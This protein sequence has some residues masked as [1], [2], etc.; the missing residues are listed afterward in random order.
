MGCTHKDK[1]KLF[2]KKHNKWSRTD[3]WTC[4]ICGAVLSEQQPKI[5]MVFKKSQSNQL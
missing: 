4:D 3:L 2:G 1:T 5:K